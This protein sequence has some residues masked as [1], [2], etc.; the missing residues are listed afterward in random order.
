VQLACQ[1]LGAER[2]GAGDLAV[3][4][5]EPCTLAQPLLR[6]PTSATTGSQRVEQPDHGWPRFR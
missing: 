4:V 1:A 3:D 6:V 2:L 5:A